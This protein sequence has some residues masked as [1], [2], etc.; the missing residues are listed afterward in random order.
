M[1]FL[2]TLFLAFSVCFVIAQ[3]C[4]ADLPPPSYYDLS[5]NIRRQLQGPVLSFNTVYSLDDDYSD[6]G[7]QAIEFP[8]TLDV[9]LSSPEQNDP[10]QPLVAEAMD[11]LGVKSYYRHFKSHAYKRF[12]M[13]VD[14]SGSNPYT[15]QFFNLDFLNGGECDMNFVPGA[16]QFWADLII[17]DGHQLNKNTGLYI[18]GMSDFFYQ[19]G[20]QTGETTPLPGQV[21]SNCIC[22]TNTVAETYNTP[23]LLTD[24]D[25]LWDQ[26]MIPE[27]TI[28]NENSY[29][30]MANPENP[31]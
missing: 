8:A 14:V 11:L 5:Y 30:S 22:R 7:N 6:F 21:F 9:S 28:D 13:C 27:P 20:Y 18:Q 23:A 3:T 12:P 24:A 4:P 10:H 1:R 17:S 15:E 2:L 19:M 29:A 16:N 25:I 31:D 26:N